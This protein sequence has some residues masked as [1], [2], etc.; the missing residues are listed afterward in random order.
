MGLQ[1]RPAEALAIISADRIKLKDA[2]AS[3][4]AS[5]RRFV[6]ELR[7]FNTSPFLQLQDGGGLVLLGRPWMLSW[8]GE[9]FHY[10]AMRVAQA[11]DAAVVDGRRDHVQRYT[12]YAGQVFEKYCL[13]LARETLAPPALVMGEQRYGRGGGQ[14]TSDVAVLIGEDLILFEVNARRIGAETL[15]SEDPLDAANELTKLLVQKINQLGV[16]VGALLSGNATLPG[17]EMAVVKRVFPVVV[18]AGHVWQTRN[19]W[20]YLDT[21]CDAEKCGPLRNPRVQPLQVLDPNDFEM[22]LA[23]TAHENNMAELLA[24]KASGPYRHRDLAVWLKQDLEAPIRDVSLAALGATF[25]SMT[26]EIDAFIKPP[27]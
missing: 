8:L 11:E 7:P 24:Q 3:L 5:G 16:T 6:W 9:G 21:A 27:D 25:D 19:L 1:D 4:Q 2:F 13:G 10:R 20:R 15:V 22:L 18:A 17:V 14:K 26:A 23:L 12:A